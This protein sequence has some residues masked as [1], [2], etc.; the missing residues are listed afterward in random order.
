MASNRPRR[1]RAT[2]PATPAPLA[3]AW[4]S[5]PSRSPCAAPQLRSPPTHDAR[6]MRRRSRKVRPIYPGVRRRDHPLSDATLCGATSTA[7]RP[8]TPPTQ[9]PGSSPAYLGDRCPLT[10]PRSSHPRVGCL[11]HKGHRVTR[12]R[13]RYF[14]QDHAVPNPPVND[15]F[16]RIARQGKSRPLF[17]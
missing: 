17:V 9:V 16:E 5:R 4:T 11:N 2:C 13:H 12:T 15:I 10:R 1:R 7:S 8:S 6:T 3:L 14:Q